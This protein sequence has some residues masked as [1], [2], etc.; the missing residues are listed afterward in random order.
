MVKPYYP[1]IA[2]RKD[3][4]IRQMLERCLMSPEAGGCVVDGVLYEFD[5][6][7]RL[8]RYSA[9]DIDAPFCWN[10]YPCGIPYDDMARLLAG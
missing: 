6:Q 9:V 4:R 8:V 3:H 2:A 5:P 7:K 10:R 1:V